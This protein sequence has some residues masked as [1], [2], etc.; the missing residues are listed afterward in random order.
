MSETVV[1]IGGTA[2]MGLATAQ[3]LSR[4]EY[5]V[6][7]SG[8]SQATI[9]KALSQI[10]GNCTGFPLD[11]TDS[12]SVASFFEQVGSFDHLALVGSGQTAWG[13]F[14][15]LKLPDLKVAFDQKFYGFFL[16]TQA[17]LSKIRSDG[18]I[19]FVIGGT[20]RSAIPGTT[21]VA[22]VNGA[23]QAMA[24]TM[25]KEL[26]PLRINILSPGLVDTPVYDWMTSEQ[27]ADFFKQLA[28]DS[29]VGR[30]GKPDEIAQAVSFL[31]ENG[32][33]TGAILDVD[34]GGRL[35]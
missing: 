27:K 9:D 22:A 4:E 20:S 28:G 33:T 30:V 5:R 8:R 17:A 18:S 2:G 10:A 25:A 13:S 15:D 16:C 6:V 1:V 35:H 3:T 34:G 14:R 19:V 31:I 7:I 29:P 11:F 32:F 21:G 23:I 12:S 24:F 26:A